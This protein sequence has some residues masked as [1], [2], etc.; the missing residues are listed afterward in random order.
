MT[1]SSDLPILADDDTAP[2]PRPYQAPELTPLGSIDVIT[3]GPDSGNID[4]IF[5]GSGGFQRDAAS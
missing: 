3:A 1:F 5:G 4:Q 2:A